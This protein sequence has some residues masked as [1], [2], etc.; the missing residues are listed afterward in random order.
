MVHH[1]LALAAPGRPRSGPHRGPH[2]VARASTP[3]AADCGRLGAGPGR[4][5]EGADGAGVVVQ[6]DRPAGDTAH[7]RPAAR[8]R[9]R[10]ARPTTPWPPATTAVLRNVRAGRWSTTSRRCADRGRPASGTG[11]ADHRPQRPDLRRPGPLSRLRRS[12]ARCRHRPRRHR[13]WTWA[14]PTAWTRPPA[15]GASRSATGAA[16]SPAARRRA[17]GATP[18]TSRHWL[19]GGPT[20]LDNLVLLCESRPRPRSTH[21]FGS[22]DNPTADGAP[23]APTAPRSFCTPPRAA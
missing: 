5:G 18:T 3:T 6:A 11:A 19:D 21:G 15:P 22:N 2:A 23:A 12:V 20:D 1:Y 10:A 4:R 13:R 16:S 17:A 7:P 8:R 14:A 9:L